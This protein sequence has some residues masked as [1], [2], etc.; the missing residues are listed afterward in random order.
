MEHDLLLVDGDIP[1]DDQGDPIFFSGSQVIEQSLRNRI[2][3]QNFMVDLIGDRSPVNHQAVYQ[4]IKNEVEQD[5]R[6]IP[7]TCSVKEA[8]VKESSNNA[9]TVLAKSNDGD[10]LKLVYQLNYS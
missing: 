1:L 3:E 6:V 10:Q 5:P 7:G 9:L 2:F 8:G 4:K